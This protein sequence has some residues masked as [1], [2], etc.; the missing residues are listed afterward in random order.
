[1]VGIVVV[2]HGRLGEEIVSAA[3]TIVG[4]IPLMTA[5]SLGWSDDVA[6]S[7][8]NITRAIE[9]VGVGGALLLTDMFGGTPT[10]ICLSFLSEK[11][12]IVT[13]VNL[14]ML[15]KIANRRELGLG[16]MAR[17]VSDQGRSAI[18]IASE[19]LRPTS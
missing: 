7:R 17:M 1:M 15:I 10:N 2:T 19:V 9:S 5:V 12:E 11:V 13:G 8:E 6:H 4:E 18:I 3:R 16:E 14:P